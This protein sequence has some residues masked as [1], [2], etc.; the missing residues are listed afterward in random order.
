M[1]AIFD[2]DIVAGSHSCT[3]AFDWGQG[4]GLLPLRLRR[5]R[6]CGDAG[7]ARQPPIAACQTHSKLQPAH[8]YSDDV[9][10]KILEQAALMSQ[11]TNAPS[12]TI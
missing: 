7:M 5:L 12:T 3:P 9:Q 11:L 10:L 4:C 8:A 1:N 2:G 6:A